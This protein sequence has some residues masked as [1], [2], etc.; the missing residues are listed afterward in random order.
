MDA[1]VA[2]ER[3]N[4]IH[5][6]PNQFL[7]KKKKKSSMIFSVATVESSG[8]RNISPLLLHSSLALVL[9]TESLYI[10]YIDHITYMHKLRGRILWI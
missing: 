10:V 1:F 4:V 9:H 8:H 6:H 5:S 2:P 7:R 3:Q